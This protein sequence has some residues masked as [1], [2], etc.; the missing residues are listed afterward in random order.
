MN[1]NNIKHYNY[2]VMSINVLTIKFNGIIITAYKSNLNVIVPYKI[3]VNRPTFNA[4]LKK[5]RHS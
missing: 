3:I 5:M 2:H 4:R 1:V